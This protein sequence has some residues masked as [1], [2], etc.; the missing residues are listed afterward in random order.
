MN[1]QRKVPKEAEGHLKNA[2][3]IIK[4]LYDH[5]NGGSLPDPPGYLH[6]PQVKKYQLYI[7]H[8]FSDII[9]TP[10]YDYISKTKKS[11]LIINDHRAEIAANITQIVERYGLGVGLMVLHAQQMNTGHIPLSVHINGKT[12]N[13]MADTQRLHG[14]IGENI[15]HVPVRKYR[16]DFN[17]LAEMNIVK[18][19][20]IWE[21]DKIVT[22]EVDRFPCFYCS[23]KEI[24]PSEVTFD[25]DGNRYGLSRDYS[26]G[27]TFAPFGNPLTVMHFLAWDRSSHPLNMTR[28]PVTAFDL[29]ELTRLI[30][31]SIRQFFI[32]TGIDDFPV[33]DG[34]SNG[35]AGCTIF[36]GHFQFFQPEFAPPIISHHLV[37]SQPIH[38]R[39]DVKV[40]RLSWPTAIY[41]VSADD[42]C[43]VGHVSNDITGRWRHLCGNVK[44]SYK[45]FVEGYEPGPDVLVRPHTQNIYI[46]GM[47]LG[48]EAYIIPRDKRRINYNPPKGEWLDKSS[49]RRP[50]AKTNIGVLE[51]TG[52]VIADDENSFEQMKNWTPEQISRQVSH[53]VGA[54]HPFQGKI[55]SLEE[56]I[57]D[58]Y[59]I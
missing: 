17:Q 10:S 46:P 2:K 27:Y 55:A 30:N 8:K 32:N 22:H 5:R 25:I 42:S 16:S 29:V 50:Q 53:V 11:W 9:N 58:I 52:T 4:S 13:L 12:Q 36:H 45:N 49:K 57:N 34:V 28:T 56:Y 7:Y 6:T 21:K 26:F 23:S 14:T 47:K 54:V 3:E 15:I 20:E 51:A 35:W 19:R 33:I 1:N 38:V 18:P 43:K 39:D 24:N 31:I 59:P 41:Q 48:C 40:N 44:V 37:I